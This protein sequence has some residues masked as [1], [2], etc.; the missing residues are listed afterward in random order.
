MITATWR[1]LRA[2]LKS[3]RLQFLLI[4]GVL[5]LSAMLLTVSLLVMISADEPWERTF[6]ATNGPHLWLVSPYYDLDFSP[7]EQ[8]PAVS[9]SSGTMLALAENPLVLGDEKISIFL[10]AMDTM[11]PVAH[12][13]LA[14]G[15]WVD[16]AKAGEIVLDYSLARYYDFQVGDKV[17]VLGADGNHELSIIGLAVTAH[18]FPYD[19]ITKDVSPGVAYLSQETLKVLQPD[20]GSWYSVI[21]VRLKQ[22]ETSKAMAERVYE[23]FPNQ[24]R[25]VIEWQFVKQNATLAD[26]LNA[27][28]M[29]LF[30]V[31]GLV[32]V[33][34]I[35]FNTIGGQVLSQYRE[36]GLLKAIGFSPRQVTMIFLGEHLFTGL[37]AG[38]IGILLGLA[39]APGLINRMAN[40]LNTTPPDVF[41]PELLIGVLALVEAT[42]ALVTLL[43]AWQGGRID[44]VQA[45]TV[46]YRSRNPGVS[47][48]GRLATWLRLPPV[49]TLGIK[50]TF[51][52]PL[53]AFMA[54]A[55]LLL[56]TVVVITAINA[57]ATVNDL[58]VDR[59]YFNGTT[60][61]MKVMRNFVPAELIRAEILSN[62]QVVDYYE[63]F[64][65]YGQAPGHM[66]QPIAIRMIEGDYKKFDFPLKE[67]RMIAKPGEAVMGYA[68][69]DILDKELG[70]HMTVF[71]NGEP[72]ELIIV[73]RHI[74]NLNLNKVIITSMD[75][76]REQGAADLQP[77][78][79]Y[80][81]LEDPGQAESL[82]RE[83]LDRFQGMIIVSVIKNEPVASVVQLTNLI[84]S[85]GLI[86]MIVA[87]ANLMS[88]SL[89]SIRERVRDYGI[90]KT[91]GVTP[92]QIAA[93]VVIGAITITV[94][95]LALGVTL[96]IVVMER[97]IQQVGIMIGAGT[98][99]YTISWGWLSMLLPVMI[100]VAIVSSLLPALRAARLEVTEA[101]RYE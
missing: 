66:D 58:S 10:Y 50:D 24:L 23:L 75:T 89:L 100:V 3:N 51:T 1:K 22:P 16:P 29:G 68:V 96:G 55:S 49:V 73:G 90:Q 40:M 62:P 78:T 97:F 11:P 4:T 92:A 34:M 21:G 19:E 26:T 27:A 86:L 74:E 87:A 20:P 2:D 39:I 56:T 79:Y 30:S 81:R 7:L 65:L 91:L 35:I 71:I 9:E 28:F 42:V 101:L 43:P 38:V 70:D 69:F 95:A 32:A 31:L 85:M 80:L 46:G 88:T 61:N 54:I 17:T 57:Q 67:G 59:F 77:N 94:I 18:W 12:P 36:I 15:R 76:Y 5:A 83:W 84:T 99:F 52:R 41:T 6:D 82:R 48:L 45:I 14:E 60:A 25:S 64:L 47:R 44:T 37:I 63:E 93:G 72:I 98:D 8:D 53:R 33:G 13:L